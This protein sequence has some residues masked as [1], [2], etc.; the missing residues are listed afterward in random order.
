MVQLNQRPNAELPNET[1]Y[2][3][4]MEIKMFFFISATLNDHICK[5]PEV[6]AQQHLFCCW[7]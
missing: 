6:T 7:E 5:Q 1:N 2:L 3:K 4:F